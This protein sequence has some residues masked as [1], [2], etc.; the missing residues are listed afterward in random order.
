MMYRHTITVYD[1]NYRLIKTISDRVNLGIFP[2]SGYQEE[3][4]G[5]PVE[6]AFSRD[7]SKAW[8]S[9]FKMVGEEFRNPGQDN[10]IP[11]PNYDPGFVYEIDT[12]SLKIEHVIPVGCVPKYLTVTPNDQYAIVSNWCSGDVSIIDLNRGREVRRLPIGAYPRGIVVDSDSRTAYVALMG[13][14]RIGII[15]LSEFTL[16]W[17][18][19]IGQTPRHLCIGPSDRYLYVTLSRP[20]IIAKIDLVRKETILS[21]QV[22]EEVR[23]MAM[24]RDN[25]YLYIVDYDLNRLLK[26]H[27]ENLSLSEYIRTHD[28]PIGVTVDEITGEIWVACYTGSI[29]VFSDKEY[30]MQIAASRLS[31]STSSDTRL[32]RPGERYVPNDPIRFIYGTPAGS[33]EVFSRPDTAFVQ[34]TMP[35]AKAAAPLPS[36]QPSHRSSHVGDDRV[37]SY[38]I[39]VGSFEDV[40]KAREYAA[41]L[42]SSGMN[43]VLL[44]DQ[45]RMRVSVGSFRTKSA[46]EDIL[47]NIK[48][49]IQKDAWI[50]RK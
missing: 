26:V 35:L 16:S 25:R 44:P 19:H 12:R 30:P 32:Y 38:Y 41:Q 39:I 43:P 4:N 6:I 42:T 45:N 27:T 15:D 10:C 31:V 9:N 49:R 34:T 18:D 11:S 28:K 14:E 37:N 23:S 1:R 7:G 29:Q 40:D 17:I 3:A 47:P 24:S 33:M 8:V 13:E 2:E 22:G 36:A 48:Q 20:G 46:A 50:L 5:A 21:T